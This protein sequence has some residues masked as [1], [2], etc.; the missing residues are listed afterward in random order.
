MCVYVY[1]CDM[2]NYSNP[3]VTTKQLKRIWGSHF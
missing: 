2:W 1:M 3:Q